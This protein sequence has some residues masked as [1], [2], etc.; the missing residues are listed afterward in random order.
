MPAKC[1]M[2]V[3]AHADDI[4]LNVGGALL[5]YVA[6]GYDVVY[7]MA[8]NNMAGNCAV[9]DEQGNVQNRRLGPIDQ[10]RV[11]KEEA[12]AGAAALKTTPIHLDHPQRVY[13]LPDGSVARVGYGCE[14]P[15]GVPADVPTILTAHEDEASVAKLTDLMVKHNPEYVITHGLNQKDMEH[16]GTTLL[17]VNSYWKAVEQHGLVGGLLYWVFGVTMHGNHSCQW[18]TWVDISDYLQKKMELV[19]LHACQM[20]NAL[21]P[22]F[23]R[24]RRDTACG[25]AC[26]CAAA[27]VFNVVNPLRLVPMT[28]SQYPDFATEIIANSR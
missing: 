13:N 9:K 4:E 2:V 15:E 22:D 23:P 28:G 27:E 11:R 17:V 7:V 1:I 8:T 14:L 3:G 25:A 12:A 24:R 16:F 10:M 20:P 19:S 18:D 26:G 5:K 21:E 6:R